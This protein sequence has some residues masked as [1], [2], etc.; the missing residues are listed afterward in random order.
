MNRLFQKVF[1]SKLQ[2]PRELD[3]N[4][5]P[6]PIGSNISVE[7]Y[8]SFI[9]S[10][11]ISGYKFNYKNGTVYIAEMCSPE[12]EIVIEI[13][14]DAFRELCPRAIYGPRKDAP[15]QILGQP[16]HVMADGIRRGTD[17]AI[18][19]H[20]T[21]VPDPPVPHPGPPPS[22]IRGNSYAR[23]IVEVAVSQS[24]SDLKEK[25]R[26]WKRQ[27]YVRSIIGIKLHKVFNTRDASGNKDR[28]MTAILWRQ[29]VARRK[30]HFGTVDKKGNR[31]NACNAANN[32]NFIINIPV[33]DIFYD[34]PIPTIG[35]AGPSAL[36]IAALYNANVSI[37]LYEVQQ[38]VLMKQEK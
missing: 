4:S 31:T 18:G 35:Y 24:S 36:P 9:E 10:K 23:V 1:S 7:E 30:W 3:E 28:A 5:L 25:C 16:L 8:N 33:G 6:F 27:S 29:G 38:A 34:P 21:F 26:L 19:P 13:I 32:P 12:H 15:I 17:L 20:R 2:I 14:G 37:D 11:E 22:D